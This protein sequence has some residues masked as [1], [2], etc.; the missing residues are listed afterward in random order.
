MNLFF[1]PGDKFFSKNLL[2]L[3]IYSNNV[4]YLETAKKYVCIVPVVDQYLARFVNYEDYNYV[5][6]YV[7]VS[8]DC[9]NWYQSFIIYQGNLPL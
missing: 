1:S 9:I 3:S 8:D 5:D 6:N 4:F 7:F 2:D